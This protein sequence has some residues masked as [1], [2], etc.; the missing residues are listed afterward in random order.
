M[1]IYKHYKKKGGQYIIINA[2]E[3]QIDDVWHECVIYQCLNSKKIYVREAVDFDLK[4]SA[5]EKTNIK[6]LQKY[7]HIYEHCMN[8]ISGLLEEEMDTYSKFLYNEN[9]STLPDGFYKG[10]KK[11]DY[12]DVRRLYDK[13][14]AEK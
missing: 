6:K 5:E 2:G 3:M 12:G 10:G 14:L 11:L 1:T 9:I 4:F 13:Y 8:K 7:K